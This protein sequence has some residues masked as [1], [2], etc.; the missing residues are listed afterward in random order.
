[1]METQNNVKIAII[2]GNK[3]F[4]N[5]EKLVKLAKEEMQKITVQVVILIPKDIIQ[6][7]NVYVMIIS[8]MMEHMNYVAHAIPIG[9]FIFIKLY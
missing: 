5:F 8:M 7:I 4:I 3:I 6:I 9:S 1:M 2:L